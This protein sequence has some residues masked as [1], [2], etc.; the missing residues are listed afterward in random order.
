VFENILYFYDRT[1]QGIQMINLT[2]HTY[3]EGQDFGPREFYSI[4]SLLVWNNELFE[5]FIGK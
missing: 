5:R 1:T 4:H 2:G 3:K